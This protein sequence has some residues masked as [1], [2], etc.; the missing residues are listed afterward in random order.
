M[1]A[2]AATVIGKP[3]P[4]L[5]SGSVAYTALGVVGALAVVIAGW[6]TA[7]P[8]IYRA[9]LALQVVTPNWPRWLVTLFAGAVTT[10]VACSPFVFT[11]L[12]DFVAIYGLLLMPVGAIVFV[13]HWVFPR[14]GLTQYW[15]SRR[16]D[17]MRWVNVPGLIAWFVTLSGA[18][19]VWRT[20]GLHH[21]FLII[22]VWLATA[23]LYIILSYM[24]GA[25]RKLPDLPDEAGPA[26]LTP[27]GPEG[28]AAPGEKPLLYY[29]SGLI[30]VASLVAC[31][32][33][34]VWVAASTGDIYSRRLA[35]FKTALIY[36]TIVYFVCG[37]TWLFLK[38]RITESKEHNGA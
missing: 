27:A 8:T 38:E 23:I 15:I 37:A 3:L 20:G 19:I 21:F 24:F 28:H 18:L 25:A 9:G 33:M 6:T 30:A 16:Q 26:Q 13:E 32:G 12:L 22:P 5:D 35:F 7:N 14:I 17:W 34:A 4:D 1:G 29:V 2:G 10:I 31:F 11:E 36:I